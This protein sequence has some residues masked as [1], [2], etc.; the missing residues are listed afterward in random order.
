VE[1]KERFPHPHSL[2]DGGETQE[3]NIKSKFWGLSRQL[4]NQK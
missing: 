3:P 1:S 2:Y 4:L